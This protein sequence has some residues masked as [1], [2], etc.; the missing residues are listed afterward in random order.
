MFENK[1]LQNGDCCKTTMHW[2]HFTP[3]SSHVSMGHRNDRDET[4]IVI[5]VLPSLFVFRDI[6][7]VGEI[8]VSIADRGECTTHSFD[9]SWVDAWLCSIS[10]GDHVLDVELCPGVELDLF[11]HESAERFRGA[12]SQS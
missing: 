1:E 2:S 10:A 9:G 7:E 11:F 3:Y 6:A 4:C 12:K 5:D 8:G